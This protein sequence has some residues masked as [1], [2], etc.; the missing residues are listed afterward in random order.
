MDDAAFNAFISDFKQFQGQMLEFKSTTERRLYDN[1]VKLTQI[2]KDMQ[3]PKLCPSHESLLT[4]IASIKNGEAKQSETNAKVEIKQVQQDKGINDLEK[5]SILV[6]YKLSLI[7]TAKISAMSAVITIP[8][9]E[10]VK[11]VLTTLT[12]Q[13]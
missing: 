3:T 1:G 4:M 13:P 11:M 9:L 5:K 2:E 7:D 10:V 8:L 12:H 6:E